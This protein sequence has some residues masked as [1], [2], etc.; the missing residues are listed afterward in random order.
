MPGFGGHQILDK[1]F[2]ANEAISQYRFVK[3]VTA[4]DRD[5]DICDSVGEAA[6]G[7]SQESATAQNA[8]DSKH[9]NVRLMGV[10]IVEASGALTK[11]IL[12]QTDAAG[13]ADAVPAPVG[14]EQVAGILLDDAG[15]DGDLV[16]VLLTPGMTTNTSVS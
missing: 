6:I 8:T 3:L 5:V 9:I 10:S 14:N 4:N 12:V 2:E 15:A 7:V 13:K 1:A 16:A 11:G